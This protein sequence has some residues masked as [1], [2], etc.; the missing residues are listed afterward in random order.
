MRA[1]HLGRLGHDRNENEKRRT[2]PSVV[3]GAVVVT[4]GLGLLG[5]PSLRKYADYERPTGLPRLR[6]VD[7]LLLKQALG[8]VATNSL[9]HAVAIAGGPGKQ[10]QLGQ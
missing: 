10:V 3:V 9:I 1:A 4:L 7:L 2:W 5:L 6:C 8:L